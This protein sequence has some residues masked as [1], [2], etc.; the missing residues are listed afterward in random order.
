MNPEAVAKKAEPY[1]PRPLDVW[2]AG[3]V[4]L[5]L[6]C[7]GIPW[8]AADQNITGCNP[9]YAAFAKGWDEFLH[10]GP[11][12]TQPG[13]A[14]NRR[15]QTSQQVSQARSP[16]CGQLFT[17]LGQTYSPALKR[18]ILSMLHPIPAERLSIGKVVRSLYFRRIEC[19]VADAGIEGMREREILRLHRHSPPNKW[20][21][22]MRYIGHHAFGK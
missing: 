17:I 2:S 9:T 18:L 5:T 12:Y 3:I 7:H 21:R 8:Q 15:S 10:P 20:K 22:R 6:A 16:D 14:S 4:F 11:A 19:C 1:D 13:S